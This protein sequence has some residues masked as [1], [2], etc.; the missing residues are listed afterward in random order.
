MIVASET[1]SNG[2]LPNSFQRRLKNRPRERWKICCWMGS[3]CGGLAAALY[4]SRAGFKTMVLER[5]VM[6]GEAMNQQLIENYP[7]FRD[8]VEGAELHLSEHRF[9]GVAVR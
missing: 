4:T 8:G 5:E 9:G 1:H 2:I 6:G 7:G 3:G